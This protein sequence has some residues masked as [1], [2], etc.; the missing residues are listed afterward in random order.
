MPRDISAWPRCRQVVIV[1]LAH[2]VGGA[3]TRPAPDS[4]L[5]H[6]YPRRPR[7]GRADVTRRARTLGLGREPAG[8]GEGRAALALAAVAGGG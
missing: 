8:L 1:R 2:I 3:P 7:R 4:D 5:P 6:A